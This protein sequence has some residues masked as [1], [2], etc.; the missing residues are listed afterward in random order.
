M[1]SNFETY[2]NTY[3]GS[4]SAQKSR[5]KSVSFD[6]KTPEG[7]YEIIK[8]DATDPQNKVEILLSG[9]Q[10]YN[11]KNRQQL[12][13]LATIVEG[14]LLIDLREEK[15]AVYGVSCDGNIDSDN[16]YSISVNFGCEPGKEQEL[17]KATYSVFEKIKLNGATADELQKIIEN[18]KKTHEESR[19]SN[20]SLLSTLVYARQRNL[21][22]DFFKTADIANKH[23]YE[24]K[25][26][27]FASLAKKYLNCKNEILSILK[28]KRIKN[29][30]YA[31]NCPF[32]LFRCVFIEN[33]KAIYQ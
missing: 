21:N 20:N 14:R 13:M 30:K 11:R 25:P 7:K 33:I 16:R 17:I 3:I 24:I 28:V 31:L 32:I 8:A 10:K 18:R 19:K 4:L 27:D 12:E 9:K 1:I 23:Y 29:G 15:S 6:Y 2:L 26:Q 5:D 22:L